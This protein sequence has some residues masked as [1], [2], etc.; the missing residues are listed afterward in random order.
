[1]CT[2]AE[3]G[4]IVDSDQYEELCRLFIAEQFGLS[5]DD[6]RSVTIPNPRRPD[7]PSYAHQ[8]DLYWETGSDVALYLNVANAKWRGSDKVDQ[9]D[10]MLLAKVREKIAAH[11]GF[12][13]TSVGFTAGAVAVAKDEGI[14]LHVLTP[15]VDMAS[16]P[17]GNRKAIRD[18]LESLANSSPNPI[19]SYSVE[20][21]GLDDAKAESRAP[22][23][24]P[25]APSAPSGPQTR[26]SG[27]TTT[28]I[29]GGG[30][31]RGGPSPRTTDFGGR[32]T[33]G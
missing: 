4:S 21:R 19:Y 10:V 26:V 7:L 17:S 11:K 3:G 25:Q 20:S 31:T 27:P 13:I 8:I 1:M 28:R 5:A 9:P 29:S 14:A 32:E 16:L 18:S 12:M 22:G 23:R 6:V 33:R 24:R 15:A 2:E 30:E